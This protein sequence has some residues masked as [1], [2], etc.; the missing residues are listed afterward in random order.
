MSKSEFSLNKLLLK[1]LM[2][3]KKIDQNQ[4]KVIR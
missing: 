3:N 1:I 4:Y 2:N